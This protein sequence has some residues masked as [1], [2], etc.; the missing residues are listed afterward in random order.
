MSTKHFTSSTFAYWLD[1]FVA[2]KSTPVQRDA[3]DSGTFELSDAA[4]QIHDLAGQASR[5]STDPSFPATW[6]DFMHASISSEILDSFPRAVPPVPVSV[7]PRERDHGWIKLDR[8]AGVLVAATLLIA[9]LAGIWRASGG[10][11]GPPPEPTNGHSAL[12]QGTA[13]GQGTPAAMEP[14]D[15]PTAEDCTVEPLTVDEVLWYVTDPGAATYSVDVDHPTVEPNYDATP[16]SH[17]EPGFASQEQLQPIAE[18]QRMWMACVLAESYFQKWALEDPSFVRDQVLS[19]LPVLTGDDE[20][21]AIL[22]N[23]RENGPNDG[24]PGET[25]NSFAAIG[26]PGFGLMQLIDTTSANSWASTQGNVAVGY[27]RYEK[28][29][30]VIEVTDVFQGRGS[31]G[32]NGLGFL[33]YPGGCVEYQFVWNDARGSWLVSSV[34]NCG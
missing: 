12:V 34:P 31:D 32:D 6:E 14:V 20:A 5:M 21:R 23:L 11:D 17:F 27:V 18:V 13:D 10:G 26:Y 8:V 29:G 25:F 7:L 22:E 2:G 24:G 16:Y 9:L 4:Y 15:L 1:A 30:D 28:D 3:S 19:Q 33:G